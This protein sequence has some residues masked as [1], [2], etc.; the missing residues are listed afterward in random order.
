[1]QS[2]DP[3]N[4]PTEDPKWLPDSHGEFQF[5]DVITFKDDESYHA[6]SKNW[7]ARQREAYDEIVARFLKKGLITSEQTATP[8]KIKMYGI[9][10]RK[11]SAH[12]NVTYLKE[13]PWDAIMPRQTE[14]SWIGD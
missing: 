4:P 10:V 5:Y 13:A 8:L 2:Y 7:L 12:S 1:M 6:D 11:P 14:I 9:D 3:M